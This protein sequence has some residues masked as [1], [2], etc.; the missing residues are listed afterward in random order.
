[1]AGLLFAASIG[2]PVLAELFLAKEVAVLAVCGAGA[3]AY[4][5]A[6][7]LF[8]AVTLSELKGVLRREPGARP[9]S[10]LD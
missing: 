2:Y 9:V 4:G 10:G 1:M 6:L 3:A 7:L 8:R 5:A